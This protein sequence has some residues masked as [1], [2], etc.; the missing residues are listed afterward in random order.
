MHNFLLGFL[1]LASLP[2]SSP[3]GELKGGKSQS[4]VTWTLAD[5]HVI[6]S[7]MTIIRFKPDNAGWDEGSSKA[8]LD[9]DAPE[10]VVSTTHTDF[11]D[12]SAAT[13]IDSARLSANTLT[14]ANSWKGPDIP[15][16]VMQKIV[17]NKSDIEKA[18]LAPIKSSVAVEPLA[19][20][21]EIHPP[22]LKCSG[23]L[24]ENIFGG[25][26][27]VKFP[28]PRS[29]AIVQGFERPDPVAELRIN[30]NESDDLIGEA[31]SETVFSFIPGP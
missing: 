5:S 16:S 8:T 29:L 11:E 7:L 17:L 20:G 4:A 14:V 19:I 25:K 24:I 1:A 28:G 10:E 13:L 6:S 2:I 31:A 18:T 9:T 15:G 26:L 27:E 30:L 12:G 21:Q 3:A 23:I 22:L